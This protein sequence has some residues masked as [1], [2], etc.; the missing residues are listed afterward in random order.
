MPPSKGNPVLV[1]ITVSSALP[2]YKGMEM[3]IRGDEYLMLRQHYLATITIRSPSEENY[4]PT[5]AVAS[6]QTQVRL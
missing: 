3:A 6:P 5:D 4:I 2:R 1:Q